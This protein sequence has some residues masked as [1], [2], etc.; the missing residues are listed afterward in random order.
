V[1]V[2]TLVAVTVEDG[3][4][5]VFITVVVA[6]HRGPSARFAGFL[7]RVPAMGMKPFDV[8]TVMLRKVPIIDDGV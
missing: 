7:G 6:M 2:V 8:G 1:R 5:T 3:F 4:G